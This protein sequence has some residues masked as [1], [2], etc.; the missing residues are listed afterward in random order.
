MSCITTV[1]Y[2]FVRDGKVFGDVKPQREVRQ[3]DPISPYLYILCAKGLNAIIRRY[4]ETSLIHGCKI[5]RGAP[6]VSHLLFADDCYL[7]FRASKMEAGIMEEI[8]NRYE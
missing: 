1:C 2:S 3:G 8:L 4:E 7:F 5:P 6:S